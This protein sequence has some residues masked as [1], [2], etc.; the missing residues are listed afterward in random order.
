MDLRRSF[1]IILVLLATFFISLG[2][3]FASSGLEGLGAT[4]ALTVPPAQAASPTSTPDPYVIQLEA[5]GSGDYATLPEALEVAPQG[6]KIV[7][8]PGKYPLEGSLEVRK[9]VEIVGAGMD[10]SEI[11]SEAVGYALR[12]Y[13]GGTFVLQDLTVRHQGEVQANVVVIEGGQIAFQRTRF[14]GSTHEEDAGPTAGLLVKGDTAG[15][16]K[17]CEFIENDNGIW[18]VDDSQPELSKNLCAD[19]RT[20]IT[21]SDRAGGSASENECRDNGTGF[22]ISDDSAPD[23]EFNTVMNNGFAGISYTGSSGGTAKGNLVTKNGFGFYVE[24]DSQ[25]VIESNE[26]RDNNLDGISYWDDAGGTARSNECTGNLTGILVDAPAGPE[27]ADNDCHD[28]LDMDIDD[29]RR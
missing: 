17:E 18:L 26:I 13:G 29:W 25:P 9:P 16:V 28:N 14:S 10:E 19:N 2:C 3:E 27:L 4:P 8:A 22:F 11:V 7:L 5:D 6:G 21:Y 15:V 12:F 23:L 1:L 20:G 24:L